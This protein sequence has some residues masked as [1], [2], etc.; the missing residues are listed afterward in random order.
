MPVDFDADIRSLRE[1]PMI[2]VLQIKLFRFSVPIELIAH[3]KEFGFDL[4]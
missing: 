1:H 2:A 4:A 3:I